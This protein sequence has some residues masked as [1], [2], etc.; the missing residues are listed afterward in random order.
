MT[1]MPLS[2]QMQRK[3]SCKKHMVKPVLFANTWQCAEKSLKWGRV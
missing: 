2:D 3:V 1:L